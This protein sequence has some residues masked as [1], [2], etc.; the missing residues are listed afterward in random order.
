MQRINTHIYSYTY[1]VMKT[2]TNGQVNY[3]YMFYTLSY[4]LKDPRG[5]VRMG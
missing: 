3:Y 5:C 1:F 4:K 2:G